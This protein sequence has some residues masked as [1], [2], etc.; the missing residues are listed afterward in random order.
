MAD[1]TLKKNET[2]VKTPTGIMP[3]IIWAHKELSKPEIDIFHTLN[4]SEAVKF[5]KANGWNLI[6][7]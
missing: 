5:S 1:L 2:Y 6:P 3:V 7:A 4:Y